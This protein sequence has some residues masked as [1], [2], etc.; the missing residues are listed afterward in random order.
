MNCKTAHISLSIRQLHNW[1]RGVQHKINDPLSLT[2]I[3][4]P[5]PS[6]YIGQRKNRIPIE[7]FI[8]PVYTWGTRRYQWT[9]WAGGWRGGGGWGW[10][11]WGWGAR[12]N[13]DVLSRRGTNKN[14]N[15]RWELGLPVGVEWWTWWLGCVCVGGVPVGVE[16]WTWWLGC[17]CRGGVPV[18]VEWWRW[19]L[20]CVCMGG[21]PMGVER[22]CLGGGGG[23]R[24][25]PVKVEWVGGFCER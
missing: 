9:G 11:R 25:G 20:G 7:S 8:P 14:K 22:W 17:V 1:T 21:G 19:W 4:N 5:V 18:G 6:F 10:G 16:W 15:E 2:P 3:S 12:T 24:G 13:E 23:V